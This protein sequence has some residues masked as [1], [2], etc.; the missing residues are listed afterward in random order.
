MI[1]DLSELVTFE[2]NDA[3]LV[4]D[5]EAAVKWV[6]SK[7][8]GMK[9]L[10][11]AKEVHGKH[12][13]ICVDGHSPM[14]GYAPNHEIT[15][16]PIA[17]ATDGVL[18]EDGTTIPFTLER[19][20]AH[21]F[22]HATQGI[23]AEDVM[24][25]VLRQGKIFENNMPKV[26]FEQYTQRLELAVR[27]DEQLKA[28][29]AEIYDTHIGPHLD[30]ALETINQTLSDDPIVQAYAEKYEIP[31]IENENLIMGKYRNE[32]SRMKEY[33]LSGVWDSSELIEREAWINTNFANYRAYA[34]QQQAGD[35]KGRGGKRTPPDQTKRDGN[36]S[37]HI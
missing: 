8:E 27:N 18:A 13:V 23:T 9:L 5:V 4:A 17:L 28:T 36:W 2:G 14:S 35:H 25:Y 11:Q 33:A 20:L 26:P 34:S 31:A 24:P 1:K 7:P 10:E 30:E 32:S 12:L 22:T 19:F 37:D 29:L 6:A 16:N 3:A 21:E 15:V